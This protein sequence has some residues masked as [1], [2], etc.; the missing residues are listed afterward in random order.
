MTLA[1]SQPLFIQGMSE[2]ITRFA[3]SAINMPEVL[4]ATRDQRYEHLQ[5]ICDGSASIFA[6][7]CTLGASVSYTHLDVYKRQGLP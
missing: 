5:R 6:L 7:S 3:A 4:T 1:G 2:V